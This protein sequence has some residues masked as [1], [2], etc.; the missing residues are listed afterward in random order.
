MPVALPFPESWVYG[1]C[2][3][4]RSI[5]ENGHRVAQGGRKGPSWPLLFGWL[6]LSEFS[7]AGLSI[8][9]V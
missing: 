6:L 5:S 1:A 3:H 4:M 2:Y 9:F 7:H 8:E